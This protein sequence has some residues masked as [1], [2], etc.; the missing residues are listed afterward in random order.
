MA[1]SGSLAKRLISEMEVFS[2]QLR[3]RTPEKEEEE[4]QDLAR[5]PLPEWAV[6]AAFTYL[7]QLKK[8]MV[9]DEFARTFVTEYQTLSRALAGLPEQDEELQPPT[10]ARRRSR[11]L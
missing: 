8:G 7:G 6:E 11:L 9:E 4:T 3:A 2:L 10:P 5:T 1:A